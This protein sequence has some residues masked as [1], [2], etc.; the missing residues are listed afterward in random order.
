MSSSFGTLTDYDT[1]QPIRPAT[2]AEWRGTAD[3]LN[4]RTG[5]SYTGAW[6]DDGSHFYVDG[7]PEPRVNTRDIVDLR[8][9]AMHA[10]DEAQERLCVTALGDFDDDKMDE[11]RGKCVAVILDTRMRV[12]ED[13]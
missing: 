5:D 8:V 1:G 2:A 4:S 6:S 12:A 9:E 10:G 7:G 3:K 13:A 11:A